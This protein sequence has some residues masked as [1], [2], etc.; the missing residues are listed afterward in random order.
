MGAA[1][2]PLYALEALMAGSP[3]WR[4]RCT[5]FTTEAGPAPGLCSAT[6]TR[7]GQRGVEDRRPSAGRV[8]L[9]DERARPERPASAGLAASRPESTAAR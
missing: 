2:D 6:S 8:R 5:A 7:P 3:C 4:P 1:S 9:G